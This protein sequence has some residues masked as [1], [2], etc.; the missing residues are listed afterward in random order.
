MICKLTDIDIPL[1]TFNGIEFHD[2]HF[3]DIISVQSSSNLS[4]LSSL[5]DANG[6]EQYLYFG[7]KKPSITS[8]VVK[9]RS[10]YDSI[11]TDVEDLWIQFFDTTDISNISFN[12]FHSLKRLVIGNN[13]FWRVNSLN[14][15]TIPFLQSI[16][17]GMSCFYCASSFSLIGLID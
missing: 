8:H 2:V 12:G 9:N 16:E 13:L 10:Q 15:T 11:P 6:L 4:P 3:R 7:D 5:F 14:M 17:F 1:L